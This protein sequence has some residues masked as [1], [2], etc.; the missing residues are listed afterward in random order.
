M[1]SSKCKYEVDAFFYIT[2]DGTRYTQF[3]LNDCEKLCDAYEAYFN[4]LFGI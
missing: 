2:L 4:V 3:Y 1:S